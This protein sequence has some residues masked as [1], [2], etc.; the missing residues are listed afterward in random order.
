[1]QT[2]V[3]ES[4]PVFNLPEG[5]RLDSAAWVQVAVYGLLVVLALVFRFAELDTVPLSSIEA[6]QALAAWRTVAPDASGSAIVPESPILFI[7]HSLSF[8]VLGGSEFA[9]R[10]FTA[11]AGVGLILTPLLFRRWIN[12]TLAFVM[13]SVLLLAP[14]LLLAARFDSSVVWA[15]LAVLLMLWSFVRFIEDGHRAHALFAGV[16]LAALV[17]LTDPAGFVLALIALGSGLL[18]LVWA[19][20]SDPDTTAAGDVRARLAG[21]P[22]LNALVLGAVVVFLTS[23]GFMLVTSGLSGVGELMNVGL[24]EIVQKVPGTPIFFPLTTS[25]FYE[26]PLWIFGLVGVI[27]V[28]RST[29][30]LIDRLLAAWWVLAVAAAVLYGGGSSDHALWFL[31]PLA[32][33]TAQFASSLFLPDIDMFWDVPVWARPLLA[34]L[35]FALLAML[36]VNLQSVARTLM[37]TPIDTFPQ[38]TAFNPL[39]LIGVLAAVGFIMVVYFLGASVWGNRATLQGGAV[40]VLVFGLVTSF[41]SGWNAAVPNSANA[42]E[43]WHV[44]PTGYESAF[45]RRD[46][47]SL[48]ERTT[49][50]FPEISLYALV[51]QDSV[52]AWLLRDFQNTVFI[53]DV[54]DARGA[55]VVILPLQAEIPDLGGSYVGQ[56]VAVTY[57]WDTNTLSGLDIPAWWLQRHTRVPGLPVDSVVLWVR[58]DIYNGVPFDT[59]LNGAG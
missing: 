14:T 31:P 39:S 6:R 9:S 24:R 26:T 52:T 43:F 41:S 30:G 55:E 21:Y 16:M 49:R 3:T 12:A 48:A 28:F 40:G 56:T 44:Q 33:F 18:A 37:S 35:L 38:I 29:P 23:T 36:A 47:I 42:V 20:M 19:G 32:Y 34:V 5:T 57:D 10:L 27:I 50:G 13:S 53:G 17:L 25:L 59:N 15:L 11:F 58:Q 54:V 2:T 51:P 22:W 8:S 46:L 45:L 1:M 4:Q 7:S